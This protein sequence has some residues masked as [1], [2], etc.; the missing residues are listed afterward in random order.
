MDPSLQQVED[1]G[2]VVVED[3][4]LA[5]NH[6]ATGR[7]LELREVAG[8]R[9]AAARLHVDV[10]AVDEDDRPEAVVLGLEGHPLLLGQRLARAR[11]L[12]LDRRLQREV[13]CHRR[14]FNQSPAPVHRGAGPPA[15][16]LASA[17]VSAA[18]KP[19][20]NC[21]FAVVGA[22]IVG[23]ATARE[24]AL[25]HPGASIVVLEREPGPA[26]HQS[27]HSSG[28]IHAGV[29]YAP[30][31]LKARLC[32]DGAAALYAYCE[33]A[34]DRGATRRQADRRHTRGRAASGSA[35]SSAAPRRTACRACAASAPRSCARS[36]PT[37][38]GSRPCTRRRRASSTSRRSQPPSRRTWQAQ[39]ARSTAGSRSPASPRSRRAA[40]V[41]RTQ[42]VRP[43]PGGSSSA[44]GRGRTGSPGSRAPAPT[45]GSFPSAAPTCA[46]ARPRSAL[47]R[48]SIYPV[49]D[50]DL[51][52]L[53]MHLTRTLAGEVLLGPTAL[54]VGARDAYRL[55]T[56][57]GPRPPGE[58][59]LARDV[60]PVRTA[61]ANGARGAPPCRQPLGLRRRVP[62]LRSRAE[63]RRRRAEPALRRPRPGGRPRRL[64]RRRLPRHDDGPGAAR[65]QCAL[66]RRDLLAGAGRRDRRP[67]RGLGVSAPVLEPRAAAAVPR[68][69]GCRRGAR[70]PRPAP[71]SAATRGERAELRRQRLPRPRRGRRAT[72]PSRS[73][74]GSSR[75]PPRRSAPSV[76]R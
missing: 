48:G 70:R 31:S 18:G 20:S 27:G 10:V 71:G 22:G 59:R 6:V 55:R 21:D 8:E 64:A 5:V 38:A 43:S 66:P 61:L 68:P 52:F 16:G 11:Q 7:K 45:R 15:R 49:P 50:P 69:G 65:P 30:G 13:R 40:A 41:S 60:A 29:Y 12:R 37:R 4:E 9:F 57:R 19:P 76:A 32:V 2:P 3:H 39:A 25:R 26:R 28:V 74:T 73:S 56:I 53:G 58:S 17:S 33:R 72:R 35:S 23:L 34:R 42:P 44:P 1:L 47:V 46:C 36:S 51:P 14:P 54:F 62:P 75:P 63:R 24:L 67:D